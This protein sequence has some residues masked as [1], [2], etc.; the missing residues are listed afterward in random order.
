MS[1]MK[2]TGTPEE[3]FTKISQVLSAKNESVEQGKMFGMACIKVN[4]KAFAGI[5]HGEMVFKL[6][7]EAH[8]KALG[9]SG[10]KL[11]D[12]SG[13]GRPMKEWVQIPFPYAEEWPT[14][15]EKALEYVGN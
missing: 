3:L 7:G 14:F 6:T 9:L 2:Q 11:F 13:I 12:P 1:Q 10:S 5:F 8:T 15:A 4:R